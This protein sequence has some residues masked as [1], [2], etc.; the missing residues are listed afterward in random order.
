[1]FVYDDYIP[2]V[3]FITDADFIPAIRSIVQERSIDAIYP[4]MDSAI[5]VIKANEKELGCLV[6]ASPQET[7][8]IS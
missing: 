1:M 7:S 2:S 4:T 8:V 6:I 5:S 3:P